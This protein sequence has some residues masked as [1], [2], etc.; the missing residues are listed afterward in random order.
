VPAHQMKILAIS[1]IHNNVVCVRKLR[2]QEANEY[3]AGLVVAM[4]QKRSSAPPEFL[5]LR[6]ERLPRRPDAGDLDY[7]LTILCPGKVRSL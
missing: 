3:E 1:D 6:N 2:V 7:H 5:L 4:C